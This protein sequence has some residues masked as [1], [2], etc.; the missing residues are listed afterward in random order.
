MW[1]SIRHLFLPLKK[2][3][4]PRNILNAT[5]QEFHLKQHLS[6]EKK[7]NDFML[8]AHA[9]SFPESE[10]ACSSAGLKRALPH[11]ITQRVMA[12]SGAQGKKKT[13]GEPRF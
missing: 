6:S 1:L 4:D 10:P 11:H 5:M 3:T 13:V 2:K 12:S 7:K 9:V 8:V